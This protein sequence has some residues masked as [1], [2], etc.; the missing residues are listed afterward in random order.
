MASSAA[1]NSSIKSKSLSSLKI[2]S[3]HQ[4]QS[5]PN[6]YGVSF[7][8]RVKDELYYWCGVKYRF[9]QGKTKKYF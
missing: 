1:F 8:D 4:Q 5:E 6:S 2:P 3:T 9:A 7:A